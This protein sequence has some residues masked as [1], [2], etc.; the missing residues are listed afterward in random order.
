M[1][2]RIHMHIRRRPRP[3][4]GTDLREWLHE[5]QLDRDAILKGFHE[6]GKFPGERWADPLTFCFAYGLALIN[7]L[8][9]VA[10]GFGF[11]ALFGSTA[12]AW[13]AG[14]ILFLVSTMTASAMLLTSE[15]PSRSGSAAGAPAAA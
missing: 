9:T 7:L 13:T 8:V 10:A 4:Q 1:G 11:K 2:E 14:A 15:T 12:L 3:P 6:S 5:C